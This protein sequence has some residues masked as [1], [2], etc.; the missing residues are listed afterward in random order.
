MSIKEKNDE[1]DETIEIKEDSSTDS[2]ED[3]QPDVV[4]NEENQQE[5]IKIE[6]DKIEDAQTNDIQKEDNHFEQVK[7]EVDKT[8]KSHKSLVGVCIAFVIIFVLLLLFSTGFALYTSYS[9]TIISRIHIKDIDVSGLTREQALEKVSKPF[10]EKLSQ[11]ITLVHNDYELVVFPSQFE[12]SFDI[13]KAVDIA[14]SKG[15]NRKYY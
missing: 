14:Y 6:D 1:I 7:E 13:D 5:N 3:E 4:I 12:V 8:K 11:E 10:N 9:S 2:I 15:R